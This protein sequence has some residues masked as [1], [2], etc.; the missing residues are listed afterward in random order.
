MYFQLGATATASDVYLHIPGSISGNYGGITLTE[1]TEAAIAPN[2]DTTGGAI[3]AI[4]QLFQIQ[5]NTYDAQ[6]GAMGFNLV[7]NL[8][9][10]SSGFQA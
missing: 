7:W 6:A 10:C 4:G 1:D 8:V 5:V 3:R 2:Q 9:P